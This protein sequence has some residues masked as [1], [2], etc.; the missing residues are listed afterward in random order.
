MR[1]IKILGLAIAVVFALSAVSVAS[2]SAT[3]A[4]FL[5]SETGTIT[6][7]A[8]GTQTFT[9]TSS[10]AKVECTTAAGTGTV[11]AK[12]IEEKNF[13]SLLISVAYSSCE[14]FLG[15]TKVGTATVSLAPYLFHANGSVFVEEPI[16]IMVKPIIGSE[17]SITVGSQLI[18]GGATYTNNGKNIIVES[19][20]A[21]ISWTGSSGDCGTSGTAATYTGN[22]EGTLN[23]GAGTISWMKQ[24]S[25]MEAS[26]I[27]A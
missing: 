10:G 17:C 24:N 22:N 18:D 23:A 9:T 20:A 6:S 8:T 26:A 14:V 5:A 13:L 15:S 7:K 19:N 21:G 1:T 11:T 4:S 16:L 12:M 3:E 25:W 2:A 27:N